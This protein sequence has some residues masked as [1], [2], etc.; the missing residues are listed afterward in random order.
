M[1][2]LLMTP[3]LCSP[4]FWRGLYLRT[5]PVPAPAFS[6]PGFGS[7]VASIVG[8]GGNGSGFSGGTDI[9]LGSSANDF[10]H[11]WSM[12]SSSSVIVVPT[13]LF[14][15]GVSIEDAISL[16]AASGS[17]FFLSFP[18]CLRPSRPSAKLA[19]PLTTFEKKV[20][21]SQQL[22]FRGRLSC[23]RIPGMYLPVLRAT[24]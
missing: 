18:T 8:L 11:S 13:P 12:L 9:F 1:S 3:V 14:S 16:L 20:S 10:N 6:G 7:F 17:L 15:F 22:D 2:W 4:V 19:A 21:G 5:D 23:F 24:R